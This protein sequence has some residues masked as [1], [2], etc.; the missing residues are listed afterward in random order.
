MTNE[1]LQFLINLD[2]KIHKCKDD[3]KIIESLINSCSLKCT[4]SGKVPHQFTRFEYE[5]SFYNENGILTD[6]LISRKNIIEKE[7]EELEKKFS[8]E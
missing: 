4:I 8:K 6:I 2:D 1:K 3:I 7:L 5:H